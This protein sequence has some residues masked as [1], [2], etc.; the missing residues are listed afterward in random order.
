MTAD[1]W[2]GIMMCHVEEEKQCFLFS[3]LTKVFQIDIVLGPYKPGRWKTGVGDWPSPIRRM[4]M[5]CSWLY[6]IEYISF[7]AS[8]L[9]YYVDYHPCSNILL[10]W[11][12]LPTFMVEVSV[13][14]WCCE[15]VRKDLVRFYAWREVCEIAPPLAIKLL[16]LD[17]DVVFASRHV[18]RYCQPVA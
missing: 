3:L 2:H 9:Q 14:R 1:T 16:W 10:S 6:I 17:F 4:K 18:S 13:G 5:I 12:I 7:L 15:D 8:H 11:I